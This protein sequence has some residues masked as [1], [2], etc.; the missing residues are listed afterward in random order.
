MYNSN[1]MKKIKLLKPIVI[2]TLGI[3]TIVTAAISTSCSCGADVHVQYFLDGGSLSLHGKTFTAGQDQGVWKLYSESQ[4]I[5]S[6]ITWKLTS[7][8]AEELPDSIRINDGVVSWTDQIQAA[9]TYQFYV[10]AT[11][12]DKEVKTNV[13]NLLITD[14]GYFLDGGSLSLQ[15][16]TF[17]AGQDQGV[18]K[19]YSESQEIESGITWKLTSATAEELPDSIRINDGVVSW[20]DQIQAAG[21][22]QFYVVA[23]YNNKEIK[24]N[25]INLFITTS[26]YINGFV[27]NRITYYNPFCKQNMDIELGV[28]QDEYGKTQYYATNPLDVAVLVTTSEQNEINFEPIFSESASTYISKKI[29]YELVFDSPDESYSQIYVYNT[30][31]WVDQTE[32]PLIFAVWGV[33]YN[34]AKIKVTFECDPN[35]YLI[36]PINSWN[37]PSAPN[38]QFKI[39]SE[40]QEEYRDKIIINFDESLNTYSCYFHATD[41]NNLNSLTPCDISLVSEPGNF[42]MSEFKIVDIKDDVLERA[43]ITVTKQVIPTDVIIDDKTIPTAYI[44]YNIHIEFITNGTMPEDSDYKHSLFTINENNEGS[45]IARCNF[46]WWFKNQ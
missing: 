29:K 18:W 13:I 34:K 39:P 43:D 8:T 16:K 14:T 11:Y 42:L 44:L 41:V 10:V 25:V 31:D 20:T 7:A 6:G 2:P 5:E 22:Y 36:I 9:G 15:G 17:T 4:E 45:T 3:S 21:T 19:L 23:T 46:I 24:T 12:N 32:T 38:D 28:K 35:V 1:I 27:D 30:N 40:K 33:L 37:Y 26:S